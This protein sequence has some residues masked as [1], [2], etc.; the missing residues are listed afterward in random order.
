MQGETRKILKSELIIMKRIAKVAFII[1]LVSA[2]VWNPCVSK[3]LDQ[4]QQKNESLLLAK[5]NIGDKQGLTEERAN[6]DIP[7]SLISGLDSL[8]TTQD[9]MQA[10]VS[11]A[12]MKVGKNLILEDTRGTN[13]IS[14]YRKVAPA[15]VF[16]LS[17]NKAFGSG[18]VINNKGY[19]I[20]NWHVVQGLPNVV[21][22]FK[23]KNGA[24]LKK[25]LAFTAQ[26]EKIDKRRDLALLKI[27]APP[28]NL[29]YMRLGNSSNLAVGQD[30]HAIG[31][32][33]GEIWTYT[34]GFISQIRSNYKWASKEGPTHRATVVQT[35]T[36]ISP[37]SSGGPLFDDKGNLIGINSFQVQGGNLNYAVAVNEIKSFLNS[38]KIKRSKAGQS[39]PKLRCSVSYDTTGRGWK[40]IQGCH[41]KS[42][43]SQPDFWMVYRNPK[44]DAAYA[45]LDSKCRGVIDT[46]ILWE[47][48]E[49]KIIYYYC[50]DTDCDGIVDLI[51]IQYDGEKEIDSYKKPLKRISILS[52]VKELDVALKNKKIPFPSLKI[53]Q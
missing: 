17:K 12:L 47:K 13:E 8:T 20:T 23:P 19:I 41:Y 46:V 15:V 9:G 32:P 4:A 5:G 7:E 29:S 11:S 24:A 14:A 39:E 51:G 44:K 28:K 10:H 2:F 53:C 25:E 37:G 36:P 33:Q 16:V 35:Q 30:V 1:A 22:V 49:R 6:S 42:S 26:V 52:L 27:N 48:R 34:K 50:F 3:A 45:A 21:V 18:V 43:S 31:H 38:K 40:D